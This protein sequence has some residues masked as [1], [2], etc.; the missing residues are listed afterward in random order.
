[1]QISLNID[2]VLV[3]AVNNATIEETILVTNGD[4]FVVQVKN[5]NYHKI[6][7]KIYITCMNYGF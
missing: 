3:S 2:E 5:I 6:H 7:I 4:N 1:M